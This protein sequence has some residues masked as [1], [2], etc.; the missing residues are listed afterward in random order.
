MFSPITPTPSSYIV[1]ISFECR[2]CKKE[3]ELIACNTNG[4]V[5]G[6]L[7]FAL[8]YVEV[9][10]LFAEIWEQL[11][12]KHVGMTVLDLLLEK[13][14]FCLKRMRY[15][16]SGFS[17][18]EECHILELTLLGY[19]LRAYRVGICSG[20]ILT[21]LQA[22]FSRLVCLS[23][24]GPLKLTDFMKELKKS[25]IE[26]NTSE[27]PRPFPVS[28]LLQLFSFEQIRFSRGLKHIKA[29]LL[30]IDN[31][32]DN[33]LP[34]IP[35]IPVGITFQI[36]VYN[37]SSKNMLWLQMAVGKS[38]QY[39]F[40]DLSPCEGL[41]PERKCTV[42]LPFHTHPN[43]TSFS[44][45]ACVCMECQMDGI[46]DSNKG[47]GGPRHDVTLLSNEI[48]VYLVQIKNT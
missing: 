34:F 2:T 9:I 37:I 7:A 19:V 24:E 20:T 30:A 8:C 3:L 44:L 42:N 32:S 29:E 33:P 47:Q 27:V 31:D 23:K 48:D 43:A 45:R 26:S 12:P 18:E 4:Y 22:V 17:I 16:F 6:L 36:T 13:L 46:M 39:V 10:Q 14:D 41:D 40:L 25:Y 1:L 28:N 5:A 38:F 35:G 15:S 11:Q 21:K